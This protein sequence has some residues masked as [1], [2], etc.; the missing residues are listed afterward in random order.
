MV[1]GLK[2]REVRG[3]KKDQLHETKQCANLECTCL[4]LNS[5]RY[6]LF[7][8]NKIRPTQ[9]NAQNHSE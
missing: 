6:A 1:S 5:I 4:P 8:Q 7:L 9:Y 2:F 3:G